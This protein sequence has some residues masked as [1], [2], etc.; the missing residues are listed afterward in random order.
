MFKSNYYLFRNTIFWSYGRICFRNFKFKTPR[1]WIKTRVFRHECS[2]GE[3][4]YE[5]CFSSDK[6]KRLHQFQR[7]NRS[8]VISNAIR[9]KPTEVKLT[10]HSTVK[11]KTLMFSNNNTHKITTINQIINEFEPY[12][13]AN[14]KIKFEKGGEIKDKNGFK[15][16]EITVTDDGETLI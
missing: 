5:S 2:N 9:T 3:G 4:N 7:D 8:C 11:V 1:K 15:L 12:D 13:F 10:Y 6:W 16:K 14:A